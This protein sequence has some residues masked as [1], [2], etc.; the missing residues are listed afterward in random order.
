MTKIAAKLIGTAIASQ[1]LY[2]CAS[3]QLVS[4]QLEDSTQRNLPASAE[5]YLPKV[6]VKSSSKSARELGREQDRFD[7]R[8]YQHDGNRYQ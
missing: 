5:H 7:I 2:A 3:P 1:L 4:Y 6:V 8:Y